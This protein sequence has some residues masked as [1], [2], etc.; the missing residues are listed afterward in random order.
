MHDMHNCGEG[1]DPR[2]AM[3]MA[4][5]AARDS[6][7]DVR[8]GGPR[9]GGGHGPF[10]AHGPFGPDGPFGPGG[11]FGPRGPWGPG[12]KGRGGRSRMF[13]REELRLLLLQLIAE[14]PR[15]GYDLIKAMEE[16]SG[17]HY[18]PSPGV[19]YPALAMLADEG[20]I[21]E[22]SSEDSRR[23]FGITKAGKD[24]LE[25]AQFEADQAMERLTGLGEKAERQRAPSIERAAFN[26]FTAVGQRMS[27]GSEDGDIALRIAEV[28]DEASQ[29]IE[30]L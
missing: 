18:A 27:A 12:G 28:L 14:E 5:R 6:G 17:G 7:W 29:K 3:K 26:L 2:R 16:R 9:W 11:P 4:F 25:A 15:H 10:G 24:A 1:F 20:L 22:Q 19:I 8:W 13:G 30:R 21:E 23:K